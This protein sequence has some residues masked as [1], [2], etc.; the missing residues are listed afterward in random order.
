VRPTVENG[1]WSLPSV[2]V[3]SADASLYSHPPRR[4][5]QDVY[6]YCVTTVEKADLIA[7]HGFRDDYYGIYGHGVMVHLAPPLVTNDNAAIV[8]VLLDDVD[9]EPYIDGELAYV[10]AC[11]L[12][13]GYA[14]LVD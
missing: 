9:L 10:P 7:H 8:V 2:A 12:N 14:E 1:P 13:A 6:V 4:R 11:V 3:I 5:Q